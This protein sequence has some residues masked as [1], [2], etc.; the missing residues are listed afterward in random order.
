MPTI[1]EGLKKTLLDK[2]PESD[3]LHLLQA[4]ESFALSGKARRLNIITAI[5]VADIAST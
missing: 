2:L 5:N 3:K 1:V 4:L